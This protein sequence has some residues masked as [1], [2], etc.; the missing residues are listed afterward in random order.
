M[1]KLRLEPHANAQRDE[2]EPAPNP[3]DDS[4]AELTP[5]RQ[6]G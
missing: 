2:D 1:K 4:D 5:D 6:R 3:V